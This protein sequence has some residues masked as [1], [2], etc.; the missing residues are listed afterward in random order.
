MFHLLYVPLVLPAPSWVS[1][2]PQAK[3]YGKAVHA[4]ATRRED[5]YNLQAKDLSATLDRIAAPQTILILNSPNNPTGQTYSREVLAAIA[6]VC[7]EHNTFIIADKI[8]AQT[9]FN[10]PMSPGMAEFC[11][12]H[13]IVTSGL[14]KAYSAGGWRCGFAAGDCLLPIFEALAVI[15]SETYSCVCAPLQHAACVAYSNDQEIEAYMRF[16]VGAH[17]AVVFETAR[18][19]RAAGLYCASGMGGF[20]LFPNFDDFRQQL[21]AVGITTATELANA[22]LQECA[23]TTLPAEDFCLQAEELV[24]RMAPMEY[25]GDALLHQLANTHH[26]PITALNSQAEQLIPRIVAGCERLTGWLKQL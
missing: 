10:M 5:N 24:L 4:I 18:R 6:T 21:R 9:D 22:L 1:Y 7:R 25:D 2:A 20:Y 13:V 8:Y 23:V 12:E 17:A 11:P 15:I 14:S 26:D 19:L 3:L 16:C